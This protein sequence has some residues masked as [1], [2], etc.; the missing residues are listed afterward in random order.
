MDKYEAFN[1]IFGWKLCPICDDL[2]EMLTI[3]KHD[4]LDGLEVVLTSAEFRV[5]TV[6]ILANGVAKEIRKEPLT[7]LQII[8]LAGYTNDTQQTVTYHN[9]ENVLKAT[10]C[11]IN[12][13]EGCLAFNDTRRV[14]PKDGTDFTVVHTGYA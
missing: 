9:A 6:R 8:Q 1:V 5:L 3:S 4:L 13:T 12:K 10:D 14:I 2:N 11:L 7:R